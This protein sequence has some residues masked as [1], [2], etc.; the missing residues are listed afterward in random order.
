[1]L[2]IFKL[3]VLR[4]LR[5]EISV[6]NLVTVLPRPVVR[7]DLFRFFVDAAHRL[8]RTRR[9]CTAA[10]A[11]TSTGFTLIEVIVAM[12]IVGL[13]V[14]TLLEVFSLGMRLGARSSSQ[15]EAIADGRQVMD[16]FLSR[17]HW[18][19][20]TERG[21]SAMNN[22]WKLEVRPARDTELPLTS[23]WELKEVVLNMLVT[24]A[25]RERQVEL[26]TMRLVKK[27]N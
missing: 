2:E 23:D 26:K 11:V 10:H 13:G 7:G 27:A 22:Q 24:D 4:D 20:G 3:R 19:D 21:K 18:Q 6:P 15:T 8:Y 14:V 25:G 9:T 12:T 16:E 17:V 1:M 5:G